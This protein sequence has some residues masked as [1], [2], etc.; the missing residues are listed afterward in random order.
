MLRITAPDEEPLPP[1]L[2]IE[3]RYGGD[4]RAR[5]TLAGFST[6]PDV[7]CCASTRAEAA[8]IGSCSRERKDAAASPDA[9][10][11]QVLYCEAWTH[12]AAEATLSA[13]GFENSS[14]LLTAELDDNPA[15]QGCSALLT[16]SIDLQLPALDAGAPGQH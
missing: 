9:S 8:N 7:L 6:E 11:P 14:Q 12:G 10:A 15:H 5:Y 3:L 13:P 4:E 16:V 1:E 2:A